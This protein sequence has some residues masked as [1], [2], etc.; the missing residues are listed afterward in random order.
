MTAVISQVQETLP[1]GSR[2][3]GFID[4]KSGEVYVKST[5]G[6][7]TVIHEMGHAWSATAKATRPDLYKAGV[8]LVK[9]S[10][11][12]DIVRENYPGL[13]KSNIDR[14][15][16]EV[17]AHAIESKG[18]AI[19]DK[20]KK[21]AFQKWVDNFFNAVMENLGIKAKNP[22]SLTMEEFT[23]LA[24][25]EILSGR[26]LAAAPVSGTEMSTQKAAKLTDYITLNPKIQEALK[27]PEWVKVPTGKS[28]ATESDALDAA[29]SI[30]D[31]ANFLPSEGGKA[32][33]DQITKGGRDQKTMDAL[34]GIGNSLST[35]NSE[36]LFGKDVDWAAAT[37]KMN[38]NNEKYVQPQKQESC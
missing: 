11:Y 5:V 38:K 28:V 19:T 12:A 24:A 16:E 17:L 23:T 6:P 32:F 30:I 31:V 34:K 13:E 3:N 25:S 20:Y 26:G 14:F 37:G 36:G 2:L 10:E 18:E 9:N 7:K 1:A 22:S 29:R 15:H 35:S 4:K 8:G 21:N 27:N 33:M